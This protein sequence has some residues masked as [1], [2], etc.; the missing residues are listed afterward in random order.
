MHHTNI[1]THI[2]L[3]RLC[4]TGLSICVLLCLLASCSTSKYVPDGE[5]L[6]NSVKLH[7]DNKRA[8]TSSLNAYLQPKPNVKW[9]S[10]ARVPLA[11][12]SLSGRDSSRWVNRTL[13][14][15]GEPPVLYDSARTVQ[16]ADILRSALQNKGYMGAQVDVNVTKKGKRVNVDYYLRPGKQYFINDIRHIIHDDSIRQILDKHHVL[17]DGLHVGQPLTVNLLETERKRITTFLQDNGYYR[18]HQ[19]YIVYD[20]D[21]IRGSSMVALTLHLLPYQQTDNDEPQL[22]PRYHI[23]NVSHFSM[24]SERIRLRRHVIEENT[25]IEQGQL[26][27]NTAQKKTYSRFARLPNVKYTGINITEVPDTTLLDASIQIETHK[28][29]SISF[30]PEGTN[31]AGDLG[32]AATLTYENRNLFRGGERLSI[33]LRAAFEA[34]TGLEGYKNKDYEEYGAEVQLTFPRLVVPFLSKRT[35]QLTNGT[36]TVAVNFNMQQ[37]PEFH[38]RV[39]ATTWRY[40]WDNE[41]HPISYRVDLLDLNYI[42]MPW[43]SD[44]FKHN[45]LDSVSNRNAIL[46]YNYEDLFIMK[47]GFGFTY[48]TPS[49]VLR[50]NIETAG[51]LLSLGSRLFHGKKNEQGQYAVFNIAYAQYAKTD[52]DNTHFFRFNNNNTLVLHTAIGLAWPYGNSHVLPFEKRYFAGGANSVRGWGV[53]RLGPG[54]F[55][56]KDGRIDFINQTGDIKLDIS[57]EYRTHLFWKLDGAAFIDA[58]NIWTWHH[59]DEQEGGQFRLDKFYK[60]LAAAY[61]IGFRFNFDY[62]ILRFDMGMKAVNPVYENSREH[63]PLLHPRLSRDFHFHFAVGMPF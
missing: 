9:F 16:T 37:R 2:L 59:Y 44:T 36:S 45:Y 39:F 11:I 57:L 50:F 22:H 48:S 28:P 54:S 42:Y 40:R 58:G 20:A 19:E 52:I 41:S 26:Y 46:R 25:I 14:N 3:S 18:F 38:R 8:N 56:G 55:K 5:Y 13:R 21:S 4:R 30:Q 32:A 7:S 6:L 29:N 62:F 12:Y 10:L 63:F 31:T 17:E 23:R 24:G 53:R 15:L 27:S 34:I 47:T 35:R 49:N 60:Q 1:H 61:G 51:N 43:I 33:S